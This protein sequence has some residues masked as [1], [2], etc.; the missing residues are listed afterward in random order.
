[1]MFMQVCIL[2]FLPMNNACPMQLESKIRKYAKHLIIY[3]KYRNKTAVLNNI[4]FEINRITGLIAYR[5]KK[6]HIFSVYLVT[7][8]PAIPYN[9]CLNK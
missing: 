3:I 7:F 4:S 5:K 2:H 9:N 1:M 8:F 6:S